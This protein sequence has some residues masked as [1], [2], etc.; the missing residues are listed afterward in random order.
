MAATTSSRFGDAFSTETRPQLRATA[1]RTEARSRVSIGAAPL[2]SRIRP[3]QVSHCLCRLAGL[4]GS[5]SVRDRPIASTKLRPYQGC[6]LAFKD[7]QNA[8]RQLCCISSA[9]WPRALLPAI[10]RQIGTL[11]T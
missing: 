3:G 4:V 7:P 5:Y 1:K 8:L 2:A 10:L 6:S 11:Q 9:F